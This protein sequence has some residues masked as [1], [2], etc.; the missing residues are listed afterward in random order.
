MG[1]WLKGV[2]AGVV[3]SV[4]A[5]VALR[6]GFLDINWP[7]ER[8]P[9]IASVETE[10]DA[11][12]ARIA[13]VEPIALDCRARVRAVVPVEGV[14]EHR[15]LGQVYR[16]DR[17]RME[18]IGDV[19]TCVEGAGVEVTRRGD[20]T[21]EVVVPAESIVFARPRVDAAATAG[22]VE[23]GKGA[24]GKLTDVF[25]WVDESSGLVPQ[26]YAYAQSV[27][28]GSAC[29]QAAYTETT[30]ELVEG[31][32]SQ[33]AEQ[34]IDPDRVVVRIEGRPRFEQNEAVEERVGDLR[35][36]SSPGSVSCR[37]ADRSEAADAE[38]VR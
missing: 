7:W 3:L 1:N 31:Y 21:T 24:L 37:P 38:P 11:D 26:G 16:T 13:S 2:A 18:A 36:S 19:D 5:L 6:S 25:P 23:V 12:E 14:R 4:L 35:L 15:L 29:M 9:D 22:S 30:E 17:L 8:L 28:G 10:I 34:G 33:L 32:R 20:G 27:I